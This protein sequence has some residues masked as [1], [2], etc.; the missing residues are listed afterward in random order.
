MSNPEYEHRSFRMISKSFGFS[1]K[2][3]LKLL[4]G[5]IT[6]KG[7]D[8]LPN[9][10]KVMSLCEAISFYAFK[11]R[12]KKEVELKNHMFFVKIPF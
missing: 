3:G 8:H 4:S 9:I 1:H 2:A 10:S 12:M 11:D 7:L 5:S 6:C